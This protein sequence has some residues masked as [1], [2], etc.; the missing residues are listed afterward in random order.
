MFKIFRE[1]KE[2]KEYMKNKDF[3]RK[4]KILMYLKRSQ[5]EIQEMIIVIQIKKN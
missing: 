5:M 2:P 1:I 3:M 4:K